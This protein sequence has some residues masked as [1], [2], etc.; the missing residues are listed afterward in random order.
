MRPIG[1]VRR[2]L[3]SRSTPTTSGAPG[4]DRF[5]E[6]R[7]VDGPVLV[8]GP[9][10]RHDPDLDDRPALVVLMPHLN[11][12]RMSGGPNSILQVTARLLPLGISVRYVATFGPLEPDAPAMLDHLRRV[13]GIDP[14]PGA[15]DLVD[16]SGPGADVG[17]GRHD[18]PFATW[19]PTAYVAQRALAIVDA[20]A[21]VYLIQDF[22]PGFYPWSTN[23]ALAAA[24]YAMPVRAIVNEPFLLDHLVSEHVGS[25]A[26]DV[27]RRAIAF[28]P[29]VDRALFARAARATGRPRRFVFYA[30]PRSPRN[31]FELGLKAL[32]TAVARGVFDAEPWEFLAVGQ[33]LVDLQLSEH[34]VLSAVPWMPYERYAAFLGESDLLLSLMLSPHTSYPPLEMAAA[35]GWV[36]TNTFGAKTSQALASISPA[37]L[38]VPPDLERLVGALGDAAGSITRADRPPPRPALPA[39]WDAALREVVPWL[40]GTIQT[41]RHQ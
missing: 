24:T 9:T 34:H 41:L 14:P 3:G 7:S 29:A 18:I 21:F 38:A 10:P 16:A 13:T 31:L 26:D 2:L 15:V 1:S 23:Y 8:G 28:M 35:G 19:W 6:F 33:E 37:I 17:F 22:E 30:R 11:V 40:A 5:A 12:G 25:F 36:V 4:S 20:P 32:R 27:D 39:S